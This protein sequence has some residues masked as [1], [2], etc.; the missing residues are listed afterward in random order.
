MVNA[1]AFLL[2]LAVTILAADF[3]SGF[4]HWLEDAYGREDFPVTGRLFTQPNI[5][6]HHQPRY[7]VRHTW[8]QSSWDISLMAGTVIVLAGT[9]DALTWHVWL[10]AFLS[11]NANQVHK[12]AHRTSAENGRA[13]SFLQRLRLVQTPAHHAGHHTDPKNSHYCVLTNVLN[14]LLDRVGFWLKLDWGIQRCLGLKRRPD[15]SVS[16]AA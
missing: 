8:W 11:A 4:V 2:E 1:A 5:L 6:H 12:W 15:A 13:I 14:P 3:A 16:P 9:L 10:F 7:F